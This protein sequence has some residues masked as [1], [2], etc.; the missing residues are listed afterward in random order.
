MNSLSQ[1]QLQRDYLRLLII[2]QDIDKNGHAYAVAANAKD[3]LE[4]FRLL[5]NGF[6]AYSMLNDALKT[7]SIYT[8]G[9]EDMVS[10]RNSIRPKLEFMNHLRNKC[11][12]HLDE[13]VLDKAIQWEPSLFIT[14]NV[15]DEH[16]ISIVYKAL[17]ESAIN[18]YLDENDCQ[19]YFRSEIDLCYPQDWKRFIEFMNE[20]EHQSLN[21]IDSILTKIKPQLKLIKAPN[22]LSY[23]LQKEISEAL[24]KALLENLPEALPEDLLKKLSDNLPD[25]LSI[26]AMHAG[27]TDFRLP[28]KGR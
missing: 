3:G 27:E 5:K 15:N 1:E 7:L 6:L 20:C 14:E 19:K 16:Y 18:S 11:S 24:S 4:C 2:R 8:M 28:K 21:F 12:G 23:K 22:K 9:D 25:E 10:M 13:V 17:L 26:K